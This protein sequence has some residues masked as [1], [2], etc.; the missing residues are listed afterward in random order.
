MEIIAI[1]I[2]F[3]W[4]INFLFFKSSGS[5]KGDGL[6]NFE[7]FDFFNKHNKKK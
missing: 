4:I 2:F 1:I 3:V 6:T 5:E 7:K